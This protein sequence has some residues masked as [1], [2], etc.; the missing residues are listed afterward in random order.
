MGH[1]ATLSLKK[2]GDRRTYHFGGM[3]LVTFGTAVRGFLLHLLLLCSTSH[4][5]INSRQIVYHI[6][7][8]PPTCKNRRKGQ[9]L[10]LCINHLTCIINVESKFKD[11][12]TCIPTVLRKSI[13]PSMISTLLFFYSFTAMEN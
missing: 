6:E 5:L 9:L 1:C 7:K 13:I 10:Q 8:P 12:S 11:Q 2:Y 3:R 4:N